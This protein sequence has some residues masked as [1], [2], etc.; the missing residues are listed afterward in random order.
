[1]AD[2]FGLRFARCRRF[3]AGLCADMRHLSA[4]HAFRLSADGYRCRWARVRLRAVA[5]ASGEVSW[6]A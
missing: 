5:C 1:M 2:C 3:P 4:G 6:P